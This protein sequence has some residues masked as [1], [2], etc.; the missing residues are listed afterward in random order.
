MKPIYQ[1]PT[2]QDLESFAEEYLG[3][4]GTDSYLYYEAYYNLNKDDVDL[5]EDEEYE[6]GQDELTQTHWEY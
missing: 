1:F 3:L 2:T 5:Y 6:R 4:K